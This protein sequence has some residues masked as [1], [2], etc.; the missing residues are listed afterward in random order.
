MGAVADERDVRAC[1]GSDGQEGVSGVLVEHPGLV[2]DHPLTPRQARIF[3]RAGVGATTLGVGIAHSDACPYAVS[4]PAPP[5][6]IHERR[7]AGC[8]HPEFFVRDLRG[9]QRRG[10]HPRRS[11]MLG[12]NV[13]GGAEH[14]RLSAACCSFH[15]HQ[16]I[17]RCD[18][19]CRDRLPSIESGGDRRLC[20]VGVL[21]L[22][23][24]LRGGELVAERGLCGEH[25][26]A[27]QVRDMLRRRRARR[28]HREAIRD[29]K[30]GRQGDELP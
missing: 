10:N 25:A 9:A 20:H 6:R 26:E 13:D 21:R 14:G 8:G 18:G 1:L 30:L 12:G 16:R 22:P 11:A 23:L 2:H 24:W 5:V 29:G 17:G 27:G 3:R 7:D 19:R 4:I 28:Q 15:D